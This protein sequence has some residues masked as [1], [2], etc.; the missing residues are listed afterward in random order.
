MYNLFE[1]IFFLLSYPMG[2][3]SRPTTNTLL[4]QNTVFKFLGKFI[5]VIPFD[6]QLKAHQSMTFPNSCDGS[7][8]ARAKYA[9]RIRPPTSELLIFQK[10]ILGTFSALHEKNTQN[11]IK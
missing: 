4:F 5:N 8:P 7:N 9:S 11:S 1:G 6:A 2:Y 3:N 10:I